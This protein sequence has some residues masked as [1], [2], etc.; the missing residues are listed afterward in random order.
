MMKMSLGKVIPGLAAVALFWA[1][2]IHA[3]TTPSGEQKTLTGFVSDTM[4]GKTHMLK[5]KGA[6]ECVHE[7][8]R[9]GEG[10]ALMVGDTMYALS[11][12]SAD[13]DKYAGQKVILTGI[14]RGNAVAVESVAPAK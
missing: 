12:H 11:G 8:L 13:L 3:Q 2:L 9:M 4:C 10:F 6:A 5:G 1:I 7:C 14:V